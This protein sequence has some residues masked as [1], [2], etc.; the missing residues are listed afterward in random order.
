MFPRARI[1]ACSLATMITLATGLASAP[2]LGDVGVCAPITIDGTPAACLSVDATTSQLPDGSRQLTISASIMV[3]ST[4]VAQTVP[5]ILP[6]VSP[7]QPCVLTDGTQ[8]SPVSDPDK[9]GDL[10]LGVGTDDQYGRCQ[11]IGLIVAAAT[12]G[13]TSVPTVTLGMGTPLGT[14]PYHIPQV[15]LTTSGTCVGP[16]D[17]TVT[18]E[19]PEPTISGSPGLTP[20]SEEYCVATFQYDYSHARYEYNTPLQCATVPFVFPP[21]A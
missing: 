13:D 18:P 4:T 14:V 21:A 15:C 6:G 20:G 9:L 3:G 7:P 2:A 8:I 1:A 5:V 12:A 17:G 19:V 16:F 11:G 10:V